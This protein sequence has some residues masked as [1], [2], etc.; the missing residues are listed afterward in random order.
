MIICYDKSGQLCNRLWGFV[1]VI[2]YSM[3]KNIKVKILFFDEYLE[4]FPNINSNTNVV[5]CKI[6]KNKFLLKYTSTLISRI[7]NICN[8]SFKR[9]LSNITNNFCLINSWEH[10]KED[11]NPS[12]ADRIIDL[13]KPHKKIIDEID[14]FFTGIHIEYDCVVGVHIRRGD[15]KTFQDGIYYYDDTVYLKFILSIQKQLILSGKKPA[16]LLCSDEDIDLINFSIIPGF[17]L[18]KSSVIKDLHSLSKCDFI[19]G[20]P[21]TFSQWASLIGGVPLRLIQNEKDI[22][23]IDSFEIKKTFGRGQM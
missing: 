8:L 19:I 14:D 18:P 11:Y 3:E 22:I 13:F 12:Y 5:F 1:P 10:S 23:S 20:P 15:Y 21:S 6:T 17:K 9:E 4:F 7:V 16:F 2:A